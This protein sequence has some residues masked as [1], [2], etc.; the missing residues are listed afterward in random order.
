[1]NRRNFIKYGAYYYLA[2]RIMTTSDIMTD[3]H[4]FK[5]IPKSLWVWSKNITNLNDVSL[6]ALKFGFNPIYIS[7]PLKTNLLLKKNEI[8]QMKKNGQTIYIAGG[9]P[10]WIQEKTGV[11]QFQKLIEQAFIVNAD[12]IALD[13]EPQTTKEWHSKKIDIIAKEYNRLIQKLG[14]S[15]YA[16]KFPLVVTTT[17]EYSKLKTDTGKSLIDSVG[18]ISQ[19]IVLMSYQRNTKEAFHQATG[20]IK[21]L[22]V[23]NTPFWFGVNISIMED[24]ASKIIQNTLM[25]NSLFRTTKEFMGI[26]FNDYETI[27]NILN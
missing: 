17:P 18:D 23:N 21:Q 12:G 24:T 19:Y 2:P 4:K 14:S 26:A 13:I 20:S 27:K 11:S 25:I 15:A 6:F 1:M 22:E 8:A 16:H 5:I 3:K 9:D 7:L 10:K